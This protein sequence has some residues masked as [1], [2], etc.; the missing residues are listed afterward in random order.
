MRKTMKVMELQDNGFH[1]KVVR[2][3]TDEKLPYRIYK[4]WYGHQK[5]L[6]KT[7]TISNAANF[8]YCSYLYGMDASPL[9]KYMAWAKK[10]EKQVNRYD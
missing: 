10:W 4:V 9:D 3:F 6:A 8:V 7:K 2:D 1:L 5:L